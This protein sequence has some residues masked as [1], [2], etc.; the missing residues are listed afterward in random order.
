MSP[1]EQI[2]IHCYVSG[3]VQGVW[4]R[5]SAQA[6]AKELRLTGWAK[7]LPDGRVEIIACGESG[8]IK[9]FVKWLWDG[10]KLARVTDVDGEQVDWEQHTEFEVL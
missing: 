1:A 9:S 3:R 2:C 5:S 7:N 4:Y 6:R 10:S 8:N